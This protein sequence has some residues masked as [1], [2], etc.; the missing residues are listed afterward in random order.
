V[1]VPN[2][3]HTPQRTVRIPDEVW[4]PAQ[5]K[6]AERGE[7]VSAVVVRALTEYGEGEDD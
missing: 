7:T 1:D 4:V 3:N 6:A 5:E 2:P